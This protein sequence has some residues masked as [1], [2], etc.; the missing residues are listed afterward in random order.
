MRY[1]LTLCVLRLCY[2]AVELYELLR[3][4]YVEDDDAM[5]RFNYSESF[6]LWALTPPHYYKDWIVGVRASA[7]GKLV[8]SITGV[9]ATMAAYHHSM[10]MCEINFLCVHKKLRTK[11]LAPVLIKEVT[12][13][14]NL[15]DIWQATYTAGVVLP[16][17]LA[18]CQY[19]HRSINP[20]KLVEVQFSRLAPRM[21]M[22]RTQRLYALPDVSRHY[23]TTYNCQTF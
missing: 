16:K 23:N 12:R 21:T 19:W 5:F 20:K 17:P 1:F 6:L 14:V 18:Q 9:P 4:N 3:D 2:L 8:A 7:S 13:R 22:A 11:R 10:V 15:C